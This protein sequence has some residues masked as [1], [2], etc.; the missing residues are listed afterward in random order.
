MR[1]ALTCVFAARYIVWMA[2]LIALAPSSAFAQASIRSLTE[3]IEGHQVGGVAVDLTGMIYVADFINTVWLITPEGGRRDFASGFYGAS[4]NAIDA[5]GN[6]LQ[7]SFYGNFITKIDRKG[8]ATL[9]ASTGLDE[10]VGIAIDRGDG[11]IYVANCVGNTIGKLSAN[12]AATTFARSELLKCPNGLA[13]DN[14]HNL[15]VVNFRNNRM[16]KVDRQG[17][18][19]P[20]ATV[21]DKGLGHLCFKKDRFY[22]AAY[23]SHS[24]YEVTLDG[25]V[26][27]ILGNGEQGLLDG[28]GASARLSFPNGI[29][30]D[31]WSNHLYVSEYVSSSAESLPRR[32]IVREI[33]LAV[34]D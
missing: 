17:N 11:A 18:V 30:C 1:H 26:R 23:H 6:L 12:R 13:F 31:P 22:V 29:A 34:Q 3:I 28:V 2:G 7:S 25:A 33:D 20:F 4:G 16:L 32:A 5:Q 8:Q 19:A 24:I 14:D 21:S 10:P 27:R 15:Y 9:L